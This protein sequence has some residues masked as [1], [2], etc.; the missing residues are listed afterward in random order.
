MARTRIAIVAGDTLVR[1][2]IRSM[3]AAEPMVAVVAEAV[4]ATD[5]P[6]VARCNAPDVFIVDFS[7]LPVD[8][9]DRAMIRPLL[10]AVSQTFVLLAADDVPVDVELL[11]LGACV[12]TRSRTN[13][14][15]LVAT[16]RLLAAGYLPVERGLAQR[17]A[18]SAWDQTAGEARAAR[19]LT[20]REQ[21]VFGLMVRG[22]S[23]TEIARSLTVANSTVKTHVQDILRRLGLR[24]R[25]EAVM[26][27]HRMARR[28]G[29]S[30]PMRQ[31]PAALRPNLVEAKALRLKP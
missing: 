1:N 19:L 8:R 22:M 12:V 21:E 29:S 20:P 7:G 13:A 16:I 30:G 23:N 2:G 11:R 25:L 28:G 17:L 14:T 10:Q 3:L 27:A 6:R 4:R 15:D 31:R 26:Y 24:N 5:I 18:S 9:D